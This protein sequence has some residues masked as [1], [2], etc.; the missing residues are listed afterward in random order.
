MMK[1]VFMSQAHTKNK[2]PIPRKE[3][4]KRTKE[5]KTEKK[6]EKEKKILP[7]LLLPPLVI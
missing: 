4:K 3:E 5:K 2:N 6:M 7:F 1:V